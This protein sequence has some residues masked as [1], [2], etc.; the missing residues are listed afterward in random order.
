MRGWWNGWRA[1][2]LASALLFT[3]PAAQAASTDCLGTA[4]VAIGDA[5]AIRTVR[6]AIGAFCPC[7]DYDGSPD[8]DRRAYKRCAK[9]V[10]ATLVTAG[11]LR[12]E[13]TTKVKRFSF[14][15]TCGYAN[16]RGATVCVHEALQTGDVSCSIE[17]PGTACHDVAGVDNA[18]R[19]TAHTHCIDAAD[20][21]GDLRIAAPADTGGCAPGPTATPR[22]TAT[23][24]PVATGALG[25]RLFDL[26]NQY[27]AKNGKAAHPYSRTMGA[28][29]AAH[30]LDLQQHPEIDSGV[31]IPHSWS[32]YGGLLWTGCCYTIDAAQ[33][34]CMWRKPRE[35]SAGLGM[36]N[37]TGNGYEIALRGFE[38][39]TPEQVMEAFVN[40]PPHRAVMLSQS[41]WQFLDTHPAMGAAMLGK[42][43]VVWFGDAS[44]PNN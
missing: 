41:G 42:Y 5:A 3:G 8:L 43:S 36:I 18:T 11:A 16:S 4:A 37:Y 7:E 15:S 40:S 31:C 34:D 23:P 2:L 44:D 28:T 22:P 29:A 19:C 33:A 26:L 14:K 21:S 12:E 24:A 38:G 1:V 25:K 27:R 35:I 6:T 10:I 13:C 30:V 32:R 17:L 20:T 39:N 9:D